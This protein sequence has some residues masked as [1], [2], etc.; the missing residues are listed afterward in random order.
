M[1][2]YERGAMSLAKKVVPHYVSSSDFKGDTCHDIDYDQKYRCSICGGPMH[3]YNESG[4]VE[5]YVCDGIDC[6]NNPNSKWKSPLNALT[7][8]QIG[9]NALRWRLPKPII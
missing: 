5:T 8:S 7:V 3:F 4:N 2:I 1:K 6:P 9:N